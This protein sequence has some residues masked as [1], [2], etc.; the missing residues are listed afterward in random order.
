MCVVKYRKQKILHFYHF[1]VHNL[2]ALSIFIVLCKYHHFAFPE[3]FHHPKQK[4][5][6][7]EVTPYSLT[8]VNFLFFFVSIHL[9]A[10]G[11]SYK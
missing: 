1:K 6:T 2:V 5:C 9:P 11:T 7:H 10:L 3:L 4:L 8:S